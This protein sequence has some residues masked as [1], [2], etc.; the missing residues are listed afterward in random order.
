MAA[1]SE[2]DGTVKIRAE[3]GTDLTIDFA[4]PKAS[5]VKS[6]KE[7]N[8]GGDS[9]NSQSADGRHVLDLR[10]YDG[11]DDDGLHFDDDMPLLT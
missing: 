1:P 2:A 5:P 8:D 9:A 6:P 3:R 11:S 7:F 10:T 4:G